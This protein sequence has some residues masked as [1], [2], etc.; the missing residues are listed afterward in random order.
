MASRL[1]QPLVAAGTDHRLQ[2]LA[3]P[4]ACIAG[5]ALEW[6]TRFVRMATY[7]SREIKNI[8]FCVEAFASTD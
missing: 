2:P 5:T 4:I 1:D 8:L 3:D 7:N 6:I